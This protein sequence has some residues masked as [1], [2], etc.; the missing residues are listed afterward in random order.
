[1]TRDLCLNSLS[2]F[3]RIDSWDG[4]QSIHHTTMRST[5]PLAALRIA[6]R[7]LRPAGAVTPRSVVQIPTLRPLTTS[8]ALWKKK[9][10]SKSVRKVR[11]ERNDEDE[12]EADGAGEGESAGEID[13]DA[14][15]AKTEASMQKSVH[16]ARGLIYEGVERA[17]G[18]VSPGEWSFGPCWRS[19]WLILA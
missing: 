10:S 11:Q 19:S 17:R 15:L 2:L 8:Q 9:A 6:L 12:D 7:T 4:N 14:V 3:W 16:W 5:L 18:R 1:M 13:V